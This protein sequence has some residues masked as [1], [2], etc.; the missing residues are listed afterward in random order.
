[1]SLYRDYDQAALDAQYNQRARVPEH[2]DHFARWA[3]GSA[4][5]RARSSC[6]LDLSYGSGEAET[7]DLFPATATADSAAPV[8]VFIHGGY[9]QSLDKGDFSFLAP[10]FVKAGVIFIAA[11][12]PLAPAASMDEIVAR[13]RA[14]LAWLWRHVGEFGGDPTRIHLFGHSAGGHLTAMMA[15]TDW[16]TDGDL[17]ADLIKS[18]WSISGIYDLEPVRRCYLNDALKMH[19]ATARRNS[20][21]LLVPPAHSVMSVSLGGAETDEFHRQQADFVTRWRDHGIAVGVLDMPG[22]NHFSIMDAFL[23]PDSV[24]R[25]RILAQIGAGQH[26]SA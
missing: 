17:P 25:Q 10:E 6:H 3:T 7:L 26:S 4:A 5:A 12:Y 16:Q 9:W 20:P 11:N 21:A 2:K 15:A 18:A 19:E 8:M 23:G 1:M 14:M 22:L 13:N 24:P